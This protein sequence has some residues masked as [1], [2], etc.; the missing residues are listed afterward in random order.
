MGEFVCKVADARGRV[1]TQVESASSEGE[2]RQHLVEKG[3]YVYAVRGRSLPG[4][5]L[6]RRKRAYRRPP[7]D[8]FLLFNQQ[9]VTLIRAGLPILRSLDLLAA[10]T[11]RPA[12]QAVLE[13]VCRRVRSGVS[14]SEAFR[15]VG[16]FSEVYTTA[17]LAG[18]RSGNLAGVLEHF[19]AYQK[20]TG[21]ARRRLLGALVYPALLIV[22]SMAV[23]TGVV[24]Y[25]IPRFSALYAD[26]G[27]ELPALTQVVVSFSLQMREWLLVIVVALAAL[28]VGVVLAS[29]SEAG[30][31]VLDQARMRLPLVGDI[32]LKFRV[33]QFARTLATL[34]FGGMPLVPSL[35][36][37][38][39]AMESPVLRH[40]VGTA[41]VKVREGEAL[42]SALAQTGVLPDMVTEMIE[43]G[44]AT[45]ALPAM[46]NSVAE[47][48]D[49]ELNARLNTLLA[50]IEPV[51]LLA[52]GGTVLVILV[53]LYLPIFSMGTMIR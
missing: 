36:T 9:F 30:A 39:G 29:R 46:L 38:A 1:F 11:N 2:A 40:A 44:E 8:E 6:G 25:I 22:V 31:R 32:V 18:E 7:M 3:L 37:A 27:M 41:A 23:L 35:E 47:F 51:L 45:G 13:A 14:L 50:L 49:E 17:L 26:T 20:I 21:N 52:V 28:V 53:A 48:Y 10:R 34:L 19:I 16:V 33:A 42:H 5:A 15:E 4:L 43:V 24:T 12:L